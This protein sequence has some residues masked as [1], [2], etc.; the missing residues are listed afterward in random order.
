MNESNT[1]ALLRMRDPQGYKN[2]DDRLLALV[3]L[4]RQLDSNLIAQFA[5]SYVEAYLNQSGN[6]HYELSWTRLYLARIKSV[7]DGECLSEDCLSDMDPSVVDY[8][9]TALKNSIM[10]LRA[11][12]I[13][14]NKLDEVAK[15]AA[16]A[17][18]WTLSTEIYTLVGEI[19]PDLIKIHHDKS[20]SP[21]QRMKL[22]VG[23]SIQ[24]NNQPE[25][26]KLKWELWSQLGDKLEDILKNTNS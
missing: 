20:L 21:T 24:A 15:Y 26:Q 6:R 19:S 16:E 10:S 13:V 4:L 2:H 5:V 3:S 11:M 14:R 12:A 17:I 25:V 23:L 9:S 22:Q 7:I 8:L 1:S 18:N